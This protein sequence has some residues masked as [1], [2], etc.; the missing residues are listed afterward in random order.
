MQKSCTI[1]DVC[2]RLPQDTYIAYGC[3][4][5]AEKSIQC[6][7]T[8]VSMILTHRA[9]L[10]SP[11]Y[12][13]NLPRLS[14]HCFWRLTSA[15]NGTISIY[16][17]DLEGHPELIAYTYPSSSV[18]G[19]RVLKRALSINI[20]SHTTLDLSLVPNSKT[21]L[22]IELG[23]VN[24]R[25][26]TLKDHFFCRPPATSN[27]NFHSICGNC[28]SNMAGMRIALIV[29]SCIILILIGCLCII[30]HCYCKK[31]KSFDAVLR[32]AEPTRYRQ[33]SA[34]TPYHT[35]LVQPLVSRPVNGV[36]EINK[37]KKPYKEHNY[38]H[39]NNFQSVNYNL[40]HPQTVKMEP[41][42]EKPFGKRSCDDDDSDSTYA[43][44]GETT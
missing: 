7:D 15:V 4:P 19:R 17:L 35:T 11:S 28:F 31:Y 5:E 33:T 40:N 12:P 27:N 42:K 37:Y 20:T 24:N 38:D 1:P 21:W 34:V 8:Q 16:V 32:R 23:E 13:R 10:V 22:S 36:S 14:S 9:F 41:E 29:M 6:S 44:V 43:T 30:V 26:A 25:N 18:S 3:V 2:K 39:L